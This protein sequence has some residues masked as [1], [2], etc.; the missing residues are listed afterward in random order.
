M[1]QTDLLF[2]R[3]S[4]ISGM[5]SV[6]DLGSTLVNFNAAPT[7]DIADARAV[8]SD[9]RSVGN[10]IRSAMNTHERENGQD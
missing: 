8:R 5:A 10:D 2:A 3:P 7:P 6:L 4:F 9:W 1:S